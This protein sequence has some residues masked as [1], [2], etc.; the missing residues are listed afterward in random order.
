MDDAWINLPGHELVSAGLDDLA[1]GRVDAMIKGGYVEP[2]RLRA[3]FEQ[4][5]SDLY[6]Y[7]A[8]DAAAFRNELQAVLA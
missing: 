2:A 1:A 8:I 7:P 4:I 6:R 5:S 3:Y